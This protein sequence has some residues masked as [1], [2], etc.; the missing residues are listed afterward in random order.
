LHAVDKGIRDLAQHIASVREDKVIAASDGGSHDQIIT[1]CG[2]AVGDQTGPKFKTGYELDGFD[3]T[4]WAGEFDAAITVIKA[5]AIAKKNVHL[6]IDNKSVQVAI[7]TVIGGRRTR[8]PRYGFGRWREVMTAAAGQEHTCEWIP[9]HDKKSDWQA[10]NL[11]TSLCREYNRIADLAAGEHLRAA[12]SRRRYPRYLQDCAAAEEW[13]AKA[14]E[15]QHE[16]AEAYI[17]S[18]PSLVMLTE[19]WFGSRSEP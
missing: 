17:R 9:S 10:A 13:A 8:L 12:C 7:A 2:I 6:M 1:A 4:V 11:S 16:T 19:Y 18:H 15:H 3:Q 14:M 5:A